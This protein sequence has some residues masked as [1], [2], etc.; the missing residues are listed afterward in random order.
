MHPICECGEREATYHEV[1]KV[2]GVVHERHL[3]EVCAAERGL[4]QGPIGAPDTDLDTDLTPDL[5]SGA[6]PS[7]SQEPYQGSDAEGEDSEPGGAFGSG[8][9]SGSASGPKPQP[10]GGGG[11]RR[12]GGCPRCG[13]TFAAFKRSGLLGC[14]ECYKTF[15]KQ[16][17]PLLERAHEGGARH[18]GK[19]PARAL[20]LS[21]DR[22]QGIEDVL[23][24]ARE[25]AERIRGLRRQMAA[26]VEGEQFERAARLRDEIA[27]RLESDGGDAL[28]I[29]HRDT[30]GDAA[31]E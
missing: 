5:T 13:L 25:R 30:T 9:P 6:G 17:T 21:R 27:R 19:A 31:D 23:G 28:D 10:T 26:A 14:P 24:D 7:V 16:L 2:N 3:C 8:A 22:G 20:R 4:I 18:T 15:E 11:E 29:E 1:V 12:R